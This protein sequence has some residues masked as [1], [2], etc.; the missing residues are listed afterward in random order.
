MNSKV[1]LGI[2]L[3]VVAGISFAM[4]GI[5]F[6]REE[7]VLDVGPLEATTE[8]EDRIPLPPV[9]G[10]VALIGGAILLVGGVR[11]KA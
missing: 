10:L 6:T 4:G 11:Q 5:P 3:L 1:I 2:V 9:V 8:T 7:T